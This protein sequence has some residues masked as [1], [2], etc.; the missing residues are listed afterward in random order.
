MLENG[1]YFMDSPG[2]Y[3]K[4]PALLIRL[5][6]NPQNPSFSPDELQFTADRIVPI[7]PLAEII[8][9]DRGE[10]IFHGY[11]TKR[12]NSAGNWRVTCKSVQW[13]LDWRYL[14]QFVYHDVDL[15]TVL[16]SGLPSATAGA[17]FLINSLIPNG[18]WTA[19][20]ATVAKLAGGGSKSIIGSAPLYGFTSYPNAGAIDNCD[21]IAALASHALPPGEDQYTRDVDDLY[22]RLGDG[23]YLPNAFYVAAANAFDTHIRLGSISI[24]TKKSNIDFSLVGQAS[25]SLEDFFM[26]LA[27]EVQ[28]LPWHDG[29]VYLHLATE[30]TRGTAA[31]PI[32]QFIDG[33]GC[34]ISLVDTKEPAVQA[35]IGLNASE[36][37]QPQTAAS[38][39]GRWMQLFKLY[40]N[41]NLT[42]PDMRTIV[43]SMLDDQEKAYEISTTDIDYHL[44]TGDYVKIWKKDV[45]WKSLRVTKIVYDKGKMA[46]SVGKRLFNPAQAFGQHL[47]KT[48]SSAAQPLR[49]TV[50]T[51]G[52]GSF[53]VYSADYNAGGLAIIY[54]ESFTVPADDT[55]VD[56]GVFCDVA[57]GGK[58]VPPGRIK[59]DDSA[60]IS[61]DITDACSK[62]AGS[63]VSNTVLRSLYQAT[64][65]EVTNGVVK[66]YRTQAFLDP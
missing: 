60:S 23:S 42:L 13:A 32:K 39:A 21:G 48:I 51:A 41:S 44:R 66:Q 14:P 8:F 33:K 53:T 47:R 34:W 54:E 1:F 11:A 18:K 25:R 57:V 16:G 29:Y 22:V 5:T 9:V 7:P 65:W 49:E 20:S 52:S 10:H 30:I 45:G 56:A 17:L 36:N 3:R 27:F 37:P 2:N 63:D 35:I 15:N 62:S 58:V 24:G 38:F 61:V 43:A 12:D 55:A 40:E 46:V 64:G 31:A 19:Y 50:I 59:I 28:F 26:K 4:F 6:K